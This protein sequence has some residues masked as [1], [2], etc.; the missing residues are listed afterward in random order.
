MSATIGIANIK[1]KNIGITT[2]VPNNDLAKLMYYLACV[3]SVV[4]YDESNKLSDYK[5][6][7]SLSEEEKKLVY[8]LSILF[9]PKI[10]IS[11]GVF[12]T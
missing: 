8:A 2:S 5:N 12:L 7:N 3:F 6:Y 9:D 11:A 4:Q 10:L 1:V